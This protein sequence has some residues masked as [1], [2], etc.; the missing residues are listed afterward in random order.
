MDRRQI[1]SAVV[2]RSVN[3]LTPGDKRK[4]EAWITELETERDQWKRQ[5]EEGG[6]RGLN[7]GS[8]FPISRS[9]GKHLFGP[10]NSSVL[11]IFCAARGGREAAPCYS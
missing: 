11:S 2:R 6:N 10:A 9:P 8:S 5:A 7:A 4:P 3:Q 1:Y